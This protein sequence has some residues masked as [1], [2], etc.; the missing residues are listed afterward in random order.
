V[1]AGLRRLIVLAVAAILLALGALVVRLPSTSPQWAVV[2]AVATVLAVALALATL[3]YARET[4][5]D[6]Q[7][8]QAEARTQHEAAMG[9]QMQLLEG[10]EAARRDALA[11]HEAAMRHQSE[12]LETFK[13]VRADAA[14]Q[15]GTQMAER[16]RSLETEVEIRRVDQLQRVVDLLVQLHEVARSEAL[17]APPPWDSAA[18]E[19]RIPLIQSQLR[20]ALQILRRLGGGANNF[21]SQAATMRAR[22]GGTIVLLNTVARGLDSIASDLAKEPDVDPLA[23]IT[24]PR[25]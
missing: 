18:V 12:Q 25:S 6:A 19:S 22:D 3:V 7:R 8:G 11:Q 5:L 2:G 21:V 16:A 17:E 15:H 23:W 20:S 9:Q 1:V 24:Q 4:V 13:A 14:T 10:F